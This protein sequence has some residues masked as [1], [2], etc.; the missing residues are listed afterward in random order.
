MLHAAPLRD[1]ASR[2]WQGKKDL[3]EGCSSKVSASLRAAAVL[4]AEAKGRAA[5]EPSSN[6]RAERTEGAIGMP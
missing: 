6:C 1:V 2:A 3:F 4:L 5:K